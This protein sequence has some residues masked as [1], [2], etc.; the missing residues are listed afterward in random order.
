MK[1]RL[2]IFLIAIFISINLASATT[3]YVATTGNDSTGD[4]SSG[5]P[6]LT[7]NKGVTSISG[8][9]TLII[10]DGTYSG[11]SNRI[12]NPPSGSEGA[13]TRIQAENDWGV[14]MS[15]QSGGTFPCYIDPGYHHIEVRGIKF[16]N[17]PSP[18]IYVQGDHIKIIRCSSDSAGGSAFAFLVTGQYVLIEECYAW[19]QSRYQFG[20]WG[21]TTEYVIFRRCVGRWDYSNTDE[22]QACFASYDTSHTAFQN[23]IAI[24]GD[25]VRAQE[26]TY[27]GIK[28]FYTPNG[29][30]DVIFEGCIVLNFEGTG[31]YIEG[32]PLRDVTV[33]N[34]VAWDCKDLGQKYSEAYDAWLLYA[35]YDETGGPLTIDHN[36]FGITDV[37]EG[38]IQEGVIPDSSIENS[39][40]YGITLNSGRYALEGFSTEDYNCFYANTGGRNGNFG[41]H[42]LTN[43]NPL[44]NSLK[45]LVRI[46]NGS[47]LDGNASDGGDIG[48]TILKKIG[49][50]GTLWGE[51]GWNTTTNEDLWP[52]PNEDFI[53]QDVASFYIDAGEA[54]SGSP[55]MNG[56]RGFAASGN[57]LYGGPITLTS[58]IWEYLGNP[59]PAEICNYGTQQTCTQAGGTCMANACNTYQSCSSLSGTCTSG[60]CCFGTC[61][62]DATPPVR[63]NRQ[64][65]GN[66]SSGTTSTIISLITNE[67]ATCKYSITAGIA[68]SSMNNTFSTTGSTTHSTTVAG[69]S[70]GNSYTYYVRCNDTSGNANTNDFLIQFGVNPATSPSSQLVAYY[71]LDGNANDASGNGNNGIVY[72]AA[73][74]TGKISQGYRFD[75]SYDN[76]TIPDS[77]TLDVTSGLTIQSWIYPTAITDWDYVVS[78]AV[79]TYGSP[80]I[81]YAIGFYSSTSRLR[82]VISINNVQYQVFSQVIQP[83]QWY[84]VAGTYSDTTNNLTIY[85]NGIPGNSTTV[86][87]SIDTNNKNLIIGSYEYDGTECF[88]GIIDDLKIYNYDRTDAEILYDYSLGS[89]PACIDADNDKY[90]LSQ[91]ECGIADCN[92]TN[93]NIHPNAT[94]ICGNGIDENC[95]GSDLACSVSSPSSSSS[96]GGGGGGGGSAARTFLL[97][98][99]TEG[100][101]EKRELAVGERIKFNVGNIEHTVTVKSANKDSAEL[102]I[103]SKKLSFN[104]MVILGRFLGFTGSFLG[105]TNALTLKLGKGGSE[106]FDFNDDS[107]YEI[108]IA[109]ESFSQEKATIAVTGINMPMTKPEK[110]FIVEIKN[111]HMVVC[112]DKTC[113]GNETSATCCVDCGCGIGEECSI[114]DNQNQCIVTQR[115]T[116]SYVRNILIISII[117]LVILAVIIFII[118][119]KTNCEPLPETKIE[120]EKLLIYQK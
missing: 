94:E 109:F 61:T 58:Y 120:S 35:K 108:M 119:L 72:N 18:E 91:T 65:T 8:G 45:Y 98:I 116:K 62:S 79:S 115:A 4:G 49:V 13:Y 63:S 88:N 67:A 29:A 26:V 1:K 93:P 52:F 64:P 7:I 48:A 30:D 40:I 56:A 55:E 44:S 21:A 5:S 17:A 86:S 81:I 19:G 73:S 33:K 41:S 38:I 76:I 87:G 95:D 60:Y 118:Y 74:A 34:S 103:S 9:D 75:G 47:S 80:Y 28:G 24:D 84:H 78:K 51:P 71:P 113:E 6:W 70:S 89:Q 23:C 90:N 3:Y 99:I 104:P 110:K 53:K 22:P 15:G 97:G 57:G 16:I 25:D 39:I 105:L 102:E 96:G 117:S 43:V 82:F 100:K 11:N 68:Y 59:C 85:I 50:S 42:S 46:E 114:T 83:N 101:V 77:S 36:T 14:I 112:G 37:G 54:Y 107:I 111:V 12:N 31:Y 92:D 2:T 27:D 32:L 66:L 106:K 10:K 69:L 20:T